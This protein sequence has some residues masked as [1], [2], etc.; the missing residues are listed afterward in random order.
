[1]FKNWKTTICGIASVLGGIKI[2]ITTGDISAAM[3]TIIAGLGLFFA[4]DYDVTG[5][6]H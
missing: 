5:V 6:N 4:K 1:M 3:G 2:Y